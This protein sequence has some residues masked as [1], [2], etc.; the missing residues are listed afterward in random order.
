MIIKNE[1]C[2]FFLDLHELSKTPIPE[3]MN[4]E[5][6]NI[7]RIESS[8]SQ[9]NIDLN[10]SKKETLVRAFLVDLSGRKTK[11]DRVDCMIRLLFSNN[12]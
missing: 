2:L 6:E 4:D 5:N 11:I 8:I 9:I 1:V 10:E 7:D 3:T 12:S